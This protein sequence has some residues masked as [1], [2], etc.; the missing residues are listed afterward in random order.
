MEGLMAT[1][2]E[3]VSDDEAEKADFAVCM[4]AG[5]IS[6]FTD[7]LT[8]TCFDCGH[9]IIFR[10]Y[11]PTKPVKICMECAIKWMGAGNA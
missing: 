10:P 8:G 1:K 11:L 5:S 9:A 6:P 7:N 4:R 3:I 2:I